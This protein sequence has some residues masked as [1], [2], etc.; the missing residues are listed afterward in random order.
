M[1]ASLWPFLFWFVCLLVFKKEFLC[2]LFQLL[3]RR[4]FLLQAL[5]VHKLLHAVRVL[6]PQ[7]HPDKRLPALQAQLVPGFRPGQQVWDRTLSQTQDGLP[8]QSLT[9]LRK[10]EKYKKVCFQ[11]QH[12][13][14]FVCSYTFSTTKFKHFLSISKLSFQIFLAPHFGEKNN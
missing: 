3:L 14:Y 11:T 9:L 2:C 13:M 7:L 5:H 10:R 6:E 1:T 8:E 12:S 4:T